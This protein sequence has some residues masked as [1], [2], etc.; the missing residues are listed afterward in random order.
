MLTWFLHFLPTSLKS[1]P[2][3]VETELSGAEEREGE[4]DSLTIPHSDNPS[5]ISQSVC[6]VLGTGEGVRVMM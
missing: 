3:S 4:R 2:V 6:P 5:T 1:L